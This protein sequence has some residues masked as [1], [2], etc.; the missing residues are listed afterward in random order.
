MIISAYVSEGAFKG[1]RPGDANRLTHINIAFAVV[2]DGRGSVRHWKNSEAIRN[3][4]RDKG[5][6]KMILSVG[7]WGA[8]G[9]SPA[10]ATPQSREIFAQSLMDIV[11]DY[12]FDG[13]DMDWEYP[14]DDVAGIEAS[15]DDKVNYTLFMELMREKLG[16]DKILSMAAG[17]MQSAVDNL[18]LDKL[19]KVMNFIN[20]MTYDMCPW[21]K[22][23]YHT[24]LFPSSAGSPSSDKVVA[25][26]EE[27]GVPRDRLVLGCGF[28]GRVYKDVDGLG[29]PTTT[30]PTFLGGGYPRI[31]E[32]IAKAGLQY[33]EAAEAPYV[34]DAET[35]EFITFDNPRSLAAKMQY[36]KE[37]GM[38]GV[39]F[40]EYT[41]D[42]EEC[43][44]LKAL[45]GR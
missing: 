36:A 15:P 40:W 33:D 25:M 23:G 31:K 17:G 27:A 10:V 28:Y 9:F 21:D 29:A 35:R 45:A 39:M 30:G 38:G 26:Y 42:D 6:L 41:H 20:L 19:M 37:T 8:G 43:S 34:Y 11:N 1:L 32:K 5:H 18:E 14:C 7:G 44:M 2:R 13:I 22:V 12:G 24:A 16:P 4:I 3:F